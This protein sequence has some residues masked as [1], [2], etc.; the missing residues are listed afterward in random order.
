M[1]GLSPELCHGHCRLDVAQAGYHCEQ[2]DLQFPGE[3]RRQVR[4]FAKNETP[5]G[6]TPVLD[7]VHDIAVKDRDIERE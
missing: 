3:V 1:Q 7:Q 2:E 5:Q 6:K 4:L